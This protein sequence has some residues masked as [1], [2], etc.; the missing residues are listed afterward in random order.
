L[1]YSRQNR[2]SEA[3]RRFHEAQILPGQGVV[4]KLSLQLSVVKEAVKL[5]KD[6][7]AQELAQF[8]QLVADA[9]RTNLGHDDATAVND[10]Q[11]HVKRIRDSSKP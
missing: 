4:N 3:I 5:G 8:D 2:P 10:M 9:Q 1:F 6:V 11:Q 7:S